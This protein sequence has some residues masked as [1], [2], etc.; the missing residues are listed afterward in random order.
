MCW[1]LAEALRAVLAE[2]L[3]PETINEALEALEEVEA[4]GLAVDDAARDPGWVSRP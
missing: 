2:G 3:T 1:Q 4:Y